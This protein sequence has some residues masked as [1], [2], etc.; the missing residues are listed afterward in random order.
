VLSGQQQYRTTATSQVQDALVT[1]KSQLV[2]QFGPDEELASARGVEG[3]GCNGQQ[4]QDRQKWPHSAGRDSECELSKDQAC[5]DSGPIGSI[6][7]IRPT[8]A[9]VYWLCH[10]LHGD[11]STSLIHYSV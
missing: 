6:D 11:S 9:P 2:E 10:G 4:E 5:K 8:P 7:P 1:P 3:G